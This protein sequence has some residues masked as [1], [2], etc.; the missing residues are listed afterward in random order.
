[1]AHVLSGLS[2][3]VNIQIRGLTTLKI[4]VTCL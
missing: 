4:P 3:L 2:S 1:V